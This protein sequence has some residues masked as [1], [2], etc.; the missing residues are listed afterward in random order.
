MVTN[1]CGPNIYGEMLMMLPSPN[2]IGVLR[3]P[4]VRVVPVEHMLRGKHASS[5]NS[6]RD[7]KIFFHK[8]I[9]S[10]ASD[11]IVLPSQHRLVVRSA[12]FVRG[13]DTADVLVEFVTRILEKRQQ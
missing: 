6:A 1:N 7:K 3:R 12:R 13:K 9:W 5:V 2:I 8:R 4:R 11:K 10:E